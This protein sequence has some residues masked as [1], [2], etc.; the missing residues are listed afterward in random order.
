MIS[1]ET[2][3]DFIC[4]FM[5]VLINYGDREFADISKWD[6]DVYS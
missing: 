6:D 3:N 5:S 1:E 2:F 4:N